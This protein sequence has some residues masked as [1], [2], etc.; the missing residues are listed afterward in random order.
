[1]K[2]FYGYINRNGSILSSGIEGV[3]GHFHV[4]KVT[5]GTYDIHF[6]SHFANVPV[7]VATQVWKDSGPLGGNALDNVV[8]IDVTPSMFRIKTGN[9]DGNASD[10]DFTFIALGN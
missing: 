9:M 3:P 7:V 4:T 2:I 1:M 10:R 6:E 5:T 8:L